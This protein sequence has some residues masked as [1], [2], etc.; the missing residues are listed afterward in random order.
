MI[1]KGKQTIWLY[2][3]GKRFEL[4]AI[5]QTV[6]EANSYCRKDDIAAVIAEFGT[7]DNQLI[8]IANKYAGVKDKEQDL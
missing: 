8:F 4:R 1:Y 7:G 6:D 5:A 2:S 3:M